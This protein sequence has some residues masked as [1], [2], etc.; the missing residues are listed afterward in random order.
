MFYFVTS[1]EFFHPSR[2]VVEN[3]NTKNCYESLLLT[4]FLFPSF[5]S[6]Q[7][8]PCRQVLQAQHNLMPVPSRV[9]FLDGRVGVDKAFV[10]ATKGHTDTRLQAAIERFLHRLKGRTTLTI[11]PGLTTDA[12]VATVVVQ[13]AGPG[14]AIP[15]LGEDESYELKISGTQVQLVAPT[16]IGGLRGFE[17]LLQLLSSDRDGYYFPPSRL[18]INLAFAGAVC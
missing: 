6:A 11:T 7:D 17:T 2:E 16:V 12:T 10:I 5:V 9:R 1:T 18:K 8:S 4:L 3:E 14:S 15:A 13:C